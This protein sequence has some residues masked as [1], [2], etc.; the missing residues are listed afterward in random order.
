MNILVIDEDVSNI[1]FFTLT[2]LGQVSDVS[3]HVLTTGIRKFDPL[4][5]SRYISSYRTVKRDS[6]DDF[7][8]IIRHHAKATDSH[9]IMPVTERTMKFFSAKKSE[10]Q[11]FSMIPAVASSSILNQVTS[12]W[13]LYN[14]LKGNGFPASQCIMG[15][16]DTEELLQSLSLM[17]F[18][19]LKKPVYGSAGTGIIKFDSSEEVHQFVTHNSIK[20]WDQVIFQEYVTGSDIDISALCLNGDILNYTIQQGLQSDRLRFSTTIEFVED[21]DLLSLSRA[22]FKKLNFSGIAHL[23]FRLSKDTGQ[24][25]L[26]DFNARFWSSILGSLEAGI[27]FPLEYIKTALK[28]PVSPINYKKMIY[29]FPGEAIK[30]FFHFNKKGRIGKVRSVSSQIK[31]NLKDPV[32]AI[33]SLMKKLS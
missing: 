19:I 22:I 9:V 28:E 12:K 4:K 18:P 21:E 23:D 24:Y 20:D 7:V 31:Y 13:E 26:V 5:Y 32:P 1:S 15:S 11:D 17:M 3:I 14:W 25:Y 33:M 2:A 8:N 27:N 29:R 6:D 10:L 16:A 30:S